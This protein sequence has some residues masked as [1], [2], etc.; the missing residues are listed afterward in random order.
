MGDGVYGI[1]ISFNLYAADEEFTCSGWSSARRGVEEEF[2][3]NG[4][5]RGRR[6]LEVSGCGIEYASTRIITGTGTKVAVSFEL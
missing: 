6:G 4:T 1:D 5:R 3:L 2:L